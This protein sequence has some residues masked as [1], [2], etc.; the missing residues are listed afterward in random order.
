M[1]DQQNFTIHGSAHIT[2]TIGIEVEISRCGDYVRARTSCDGPGEPEECPIEYLSELDGEIF[3]ESRASFFF[4]GCYW[5]LDEI[6]AV[7]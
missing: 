6:M 5:F 3:E 4:H 2:N 1:F 7:R